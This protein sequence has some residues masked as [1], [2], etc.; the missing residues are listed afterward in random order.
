MT[1]TKKK[2]GAVVAL[3]TVL[4]AAAVMVASTASAAGQ[5]IVIGWA[6]DS[7][8]AMAPFDGPALAAA[9]IR[10]GQVNARGGVKGTPAQ[11][12]HLRHAGQQAG[13]REVVCREADRRQGRRHLHDVRRRLRRARRAGSDQR[14][15]AHRRPVHRHRPDGPEA[16]R[17]EGP[18][19]VLVRQRRAGRGLGH[20]AVRVR[21]GLEDGGARN[22]HGDRVLQG[23]REG[24]QGAVHAAR[25]QD[26]RG[27]ELPVARQHE[28]A[29]RDHA[30][31]RQEGRRDR[32]GDR[33]CVRRAAAD[34]GGPPLARQQHADAQLV[35]R[36]RHVLGHEGADGVELLL[37]HV[38]LD[39]R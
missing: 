28:P 14:R 21:Q 24:V 27:G 35:G 19:G 31:Q 38:R 18:A 39:L 10:V 15:Q 25:R 30:A 33:R 8:G 37:R 20:G 2:A 26:R 12:R 7:K 4:V 36:R 29:E 9:Q 6:F 11:D 22:G 23:R 1:A 16:L 32:D 34:P 17:A 13:D 5:P 3:L